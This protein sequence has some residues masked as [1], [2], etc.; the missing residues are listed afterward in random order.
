MNINDAQHDRQRVVIT[1]LGAVSPLGLDV[2]STWQGLI[3]GKSG[4]SAITAFDTR[5]FPTKIAA[6]VQGF[7]PTLY[8]NQREARR[9][10]PFIL[11][12]LAAAHEAVTRARLDL[13]Q[14]D[15]T[16]VGVE[17]GSGLGGTSIVEEQRLILE[18]KGLRHINPSMMPAILINTAACMVAIQLGI[19]GPVNS[20][21]SACA[22]GLTSLGDA[23]RRVAWGDADVMLAGGAE[24]VTTP[25]SI[26]GFSRLGALS[27]K[28]DTPEKA[29]APFDAERDGTVIGEGAAV[30]VLETLGHALG[31]NAP[32]LAEVLGYGLTCDAY[33]T[34]APDPSGDGAARA[35]SNALRDGGASPDG[36]DYICAHG[37]G[38]EL[39]DTSETLAIKTALGERAYE[40]PVSSN[41]GAVGH[42][43]GAAG[44]ISTV[45]GVQA[46]LTGLVPP[47]I[48]YQTPDPECDLDYVPNV[49]RE[50]TVNTV[51]INS[52]GLGG[53][54]ACL[55]LRRWDGR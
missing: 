43:I 48:N 32:I 19:K 20:G 14:E 13:S 53:Q 51:M 33:H 2:A 26:A 1:G 17:I 8:L 40:V 24:S 18:N 52:F 42:M 27:K 38:T 31:R 46:I 10:S 22:S 44:A 6:S 36:V 3:E 54:N 35:M 30:L 5:D 25:L 28:N 11:Y 4:V 12:A 21:V 37:T 47:T 45:A 55:V 23:A 50:T 34:A 7:D 16:R 39:N 49:A 15:P 9:M 41:K 29:C